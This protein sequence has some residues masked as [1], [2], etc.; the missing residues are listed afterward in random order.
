MRYELEK[1]IKKQRAE[2]DA[3]A[4]DLQ[5]LHVRKRASEAVLNELESLLRLTPKDTDNGIAVERHLRVD[6]DPY[7][8]REVLRKE[9][10]SLH[11]K[12][13]LEKIGGDTGRNRRSSLSAQLGNYANKNEV[14][15]KTGPNT[16]GLLDYGPEPVTLD[17]ERSFVAMENV[18]EEI[19]AESLSGDPD[20]PF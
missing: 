7:K 19:V 14:F 12:E 16:F 13:I 18:E 10:R 15:T 11:I 20:I 1:R 3:I 2:L 9:R 17:D 8:T 5:T 4:S 6:S